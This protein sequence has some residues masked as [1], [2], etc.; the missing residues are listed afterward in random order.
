MS[1]PP[2]N[3]YDAIIMAVAHDEFKAMSLD[4]VKAFGKDKC[5]IYD[6]KNILPASMIDGSL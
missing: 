2:A 6:I 3:A 5:V 4:D 1:E